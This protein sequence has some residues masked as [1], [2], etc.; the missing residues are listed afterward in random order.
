MDEEI[1]AR[2]EKAEA[3]VREMAK[4]FTTFIENDMAQA[5]TSLQ[6]ALA[7]PDD[8]EAALADYYAALHNIKGLGGSFGYQLMTQVA[9]SN[10]R[11]LRDTDGGDGEVLKICRAHMHALN[12]ILEKDI[13]GDGGEYGDK[14][15]AEL[16]G[17]V[18]GVLPAPE[19]A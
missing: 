13:Q 1:A 10:C 12:T 17:A 11:L 16:T 3:A 4:S 9:D 15:V 8:C 19:E 7:T 14:I 5:R 18:D 2:L 6:R